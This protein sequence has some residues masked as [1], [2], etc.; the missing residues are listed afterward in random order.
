[1]SQI[2]GITLK[3]ILELIR[4]GCE[5]D[6]SGSVYRISKNNTPTQRAMLSIYNSEI[7]NQILFSQFEQCN[8]LLLQT[9]LYQS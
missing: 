9:I 5:L 6:S 1:L 8:C 2:K 3:H 7:A 4:V